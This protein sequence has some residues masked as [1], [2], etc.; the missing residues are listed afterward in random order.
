MKNK[1]ELLEEEREQLLKTLKK[2]FEKMLK[3]TLKKEISLQQLVV[4][5]WEICMIKLNLFDN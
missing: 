3:N 2:R 5:T 4:E 1:K